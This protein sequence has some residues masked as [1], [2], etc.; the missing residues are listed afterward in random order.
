ML[1][2]LFQLFACLYKLTWLP[3]TVL[4]FITCAVVFYKDISCMSRKRKMQHI[5]K[6][7][8]WLNEEGL[9][10]DN[11]VRSEGAHPLYGALSLSRNGIAPRLSVH[12]P[13]RISRRRK[14]RRRPIDKITPVHETESPRVVNRHSL[15]LMLCR[16]TSVSLA[17]AAAWHRGTRHLRYT[18]TWKEAQ[19]ALKF[20]ASEVGENL[21]Y[22]LLPHC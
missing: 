20:E 2:W 10:T 17:I 3:V 8:H 16:V 5:L 12:R 4:I 18:A 15:P 13:R 19:A 11:E 6:T 1:W 21:R 9:Q 22:R 7:T 14:V